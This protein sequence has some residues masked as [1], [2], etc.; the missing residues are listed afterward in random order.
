MGSFQLLHCSMGLW[1]RNVLGD[2][3]CSGSRPGNN[4]AFISGKGNWTYNPYPSVVSEYFKIIIQIS[5]G[6][7]VVVEA[8]QHAWKMLP[9]L[10]LCLFLIYGSLGICLRI[11][12]QAWLFQFFRTGHGIM[13][14]H[15]PLGYFMFFRCD[16]I[17]VHLASTTP[18][19]SLSHMHIQTLT[20][21]ED[22]HAVDYSKSTKLL[23]K[24]LNKISFCTVCVY[25]S[26]GLSACVLSAALA[27]AVIII[28][29]SRSLQVIVR[30]STQIRKRAGS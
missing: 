19:H 13:E 30:Y 9:S 16:S 10:G 21:W 14:Q 5:G 7:T 26:A 15:L 8:K 1:Y 12:R 20:W 11:G 28:V 29:M 17:Y 18:A 4:L 3:T 6:Q 2:N 24:T 27:N 22:G 25:L 23:S